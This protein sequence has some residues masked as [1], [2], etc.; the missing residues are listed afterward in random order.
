MINH[1]TKLEEH[2]VCVASKKQLPVMVKV[3]FLV[4]GRENRL[5]DLLRILLV[6]YSIKW[7]Q[8]KSGKIISNVHI[9]IHN[10]SVTKSS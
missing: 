2:V 3:C 7:F 9:F 4:L 8:T 1:E 6:C 5:D 10:G